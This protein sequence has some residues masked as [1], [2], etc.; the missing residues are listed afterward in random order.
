MIKR[1]ENF[2]ERHPFLA[3]LIVILLFIHA[4]LLMGMSESAWGPV[5]EY[6]HP[7]FWGYYDES[8]RR[9]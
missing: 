3:S 2:C 4:L 1:F 6:T 7:D 8:G 5:N 9:Q